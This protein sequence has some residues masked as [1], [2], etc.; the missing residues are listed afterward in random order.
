[1]FFNANMP[2]DTGRARLFDGELGK[3]MAE[4]R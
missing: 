2:F 3:V 4:E 1:M